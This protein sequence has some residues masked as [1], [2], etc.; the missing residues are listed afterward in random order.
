M[1]ELRYGLREG[2][3][4]GRE[5][6]ITP[7]MYLHRLGGHFVKLQ[8]GNA[9]LC[10]TG[11]AV[12]A[13][14]ATAPKQATGKESWKGSASNEEDKLF[15]VYGADNV[16]ELPV[17]EANASLAASFIGHGAALV[18]TGAT[19]ALI[20]KAKIAG[21]VTASPVSIVDVDTANKTVFVKIKYGAHQAI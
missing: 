6:P 15:V 20:Q 12:V 5:V 21:S 11:D 19:Y 4:K 16:F 9:T 14:W 3:G 7:N 13:G 1:G 17:D 18:N 2:L 10:A 8:A